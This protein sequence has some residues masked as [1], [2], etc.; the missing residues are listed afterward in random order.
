MAFGKKNQPGLVCRKQNGATR[1]QGT[2]TAYICFLHYLC[3]WLGL[4]GTS[5]KASHPSQSLLIE[6]LSCPRFSSERSFFLASP[7][8]LQ[9]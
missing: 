1:K 9:P 3:I 8:K 5:Q 2:L 6:P 4:A 7:L